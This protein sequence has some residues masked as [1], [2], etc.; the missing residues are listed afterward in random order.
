MTRTIQAVSPRFL[1]SSRHWR[2]RLVGAKRPLSFGE[3]PG[4]EIVE[5][6]TLARA[7]QNL[8]LSDQ[9]QGI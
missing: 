2:A 7:G 5:K 4:E 3:D 8:L 1:V 6:E 9:A